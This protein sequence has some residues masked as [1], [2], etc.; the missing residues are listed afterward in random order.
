MPV[1]NS[2]TSSIGMGCTP[3]ELPERLCLL[4]RVTEDQS[5]AALGMNT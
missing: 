1:E 4:L 5:R 3:A 2:V